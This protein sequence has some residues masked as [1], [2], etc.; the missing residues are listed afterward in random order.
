MN[1]LFICSRNQW[2][3]PTAEHVFRDYPGVYTRSAGTEPSAR[4]RL[5]K[6]VLCW[7]DLVFVM[8]KRHRERI[9]SLFPDVATQ[10]HL[11]VLNIPD[12][13]Q[14]M[15]AELVEMLKAEVEPHLA[16]FSSQSTS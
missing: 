14:F 3:N 15:D 13:F 9:S 1:L 2:R 11:I 16:R 12:D 4:I 8:E 6:K 5:T 10:L 7:A